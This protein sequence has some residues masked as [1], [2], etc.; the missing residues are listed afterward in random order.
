MVEVSVGRDLSTDCLDLTIVPL[1]PVPP[2]ECGETIP[3]S[4]VTHKALQI[5]SA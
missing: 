5:A 1:T 2:A 3:T 4:N